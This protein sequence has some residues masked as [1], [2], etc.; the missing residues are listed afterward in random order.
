MTLGE[1]YYHWHPRYYRARRAVLPW[2][3]GCKKLH[4]PLLPHRSG[5][6]P[7]SRGTTAPRGGTTVK[8]RGTTART[9]GTTASTA[10]VVS[11]SH[12]KDNEGQLQSARKGGAS[13]RVIPPYLSDADPLLIVRLSY[14]STPPKRNVEQRRLH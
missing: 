13:V 5:T 12:N 8:S 7:G 9:C 1:Q 6:R 4:P 3:R 2:G 10:V 11:L 14:D